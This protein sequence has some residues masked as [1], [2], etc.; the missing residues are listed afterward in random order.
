[1]SEINSENENSEQSVRRV[2]YDVYTDAT[3]KPRRKKKAIESL[4]EIYGY[5]LAIVIALIMKAEFSGNLNIISQNNEISGISFSKGRITKIDSNDK[6][7]FMGELLIKDGIITLEKLTELLRNQKKPLGEILITNNILT[8]EQIIQI[9]VKQMRLR[10]SKFINNIKYRLNFSESEIIDHGL[11][12]SYL[13]YLVL[14]QDWVAGRFDS[15]WLK[16]HYVEMSEDQIEK[17][18]LDSSYNSILNL[19]LAQDLAKHLSL[20]NDKQK[21][22]DVIGSANTTKDIDYLYK[23]FHYGVLIGLVS[24][25]H[26]SSNETNSDI[27]LKNIYQACSKKSGVALVETLAHILK[28]KPTEID[29]IFQA[30]NNYIHTYSGED[31]EMKN[32][33]FRIVLEMLS[34]KQQYADEIN[35]KYSENSHSDG[36]AETSQKMSEIYKDLLHKNLF[37]AMDKLKKIAP[38]NGQIPKIKLYQIWIRLLMINQNNISINMSEIERDLLQI[39]PEDKDTADFYYVKSMIAH[40]K[41]DLNLSDSLYNKACQLKPEFK[42]FL[43]YQKKENIIQKLFKFSFFLFLSMLL[44]NQKTFSQDNQIQNKVPFVYLN[45]FIN[46]KIFEK[47]TLF[48]N[49]KKYSTNDLLLENINSSLTAELKNNLVDFK[50]SI[51]FIYLNSKTKK[52]ILAKS[53]LTN[54][55][56]KILST[57]KENSDFICFI[58]ISNYSELKICKSLNAENSESNAKA[59]TVNSQPVENEGQIILNDTNLNLNLNLEFANGDFINFVTSKRNIFPKKINK[60]SNSE[61]IVLEWVDKKNSTLA[62]KDSININ[63]NDFDIQMDPLISIK[64]GL[65]F[66]NTINVSNNFS[67]TYSGRDTIYIKYYNKIVLEPIVVF[68]ELN[69]ISETTDAKLISDAG[70]G[71]TATYDRHLTNGANVFGTLGFYLTKISPNIGSANLNQGR[72]DPNEKF[73]FPM[74]TVGYKISLNSEWNTTALAKAQEYSFYSQTDENQIEVSK[75]MILSLGAGTDY[76]LLNMNKWNFNAGTNLL[77]TLPTKVENSSSTQIGFILVVDLKTSYRL[78]WGKVLGGIEWNNRQ[79]QNDTYKYKS[80]TLIYKFGANYLF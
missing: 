7:T 39:L 12:I 48:I 53:K 73:I 2:L 47:N 6:E 63:Q 58:S 61:N 1:M 13:D 30:I 51:K 49:D 44:I 68:E 14:A 80:T 18:A 67:A 43:I 35:K 9:L 20:S 76:D 23:C 64:Q 78:S 15:E 4:D 74:A 59:L 34:K 62:W 11:S 24:L 33:M 65:Y 22:S 56:Y 8:K 42:K 75:S 70:A 37:V 32:N 50:G 19:Q 55:K 66:N 69:G 5:D 26:D 72:L 36:H 54:G 41:K 71:L 17:I 27:V 57:R 77:F 3:S 29:S 60:D 25:K 31:V 10:L 40:I 38:Q 46:Y 28:F 16:L 79:N 52:Q 45:Q 21:F